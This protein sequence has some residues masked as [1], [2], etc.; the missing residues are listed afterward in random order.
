MRT[1]PSHTFSDRLSRI[2]YLLRHTFTVVGRDTD[3]VTPWVRMIVYAVVMVTAFFVGVLATG[4]GA[5]LIGAAAFG[6]AVLMFL[7]KY[8]FYNYREVAQSWLVYETIC[9]RDRTYAEAAAT[10]AQR[11]SGVWT[12]AGLD[13]LM[14][15]L[16]S[17]R[18]SNKEGWGQK[19]VNLI[20]S[21]LNEVWDLVNHYMLPAIA[22][23]DLTLT[24]GGKKMKALRHQVPETLTGVF[25]IDFIGRIVGQVTGILYVGL[26]LV[27]AG[28]M[29]LGGEALPAA[30]TFTLP[31]NPFGSGPLVLNV[32]PLI[33]GVYVAK[34]VGVVFERVVT[35]VKVIYFTIFYTQITHRD[36]IA[37]DLRPQLVHYLR[38]EE[39]PVEGTA[40]APQGVA[41][42]GQ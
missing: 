13:L 15:Y 22:V 1:D 24:E 18:G 39:Q 41:P 28:A 32:L 27:A 9:G 36:H 42:S 10:A 29:Y 2:G 14:A 4:M 40:S 37:D 3:I 31:D 34:V 23:D 8:V 21:G 33:L 7:Y 30:F 35:S 19:L 25:G 12:L 20:L 6:L 38:M 16:M 26:V 5:G 11:K 17:Q